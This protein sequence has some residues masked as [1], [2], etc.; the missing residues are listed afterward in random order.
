MVKRK[1]K[2]GLTLFT[3]EL[4]NGNISLSFQVLY[5]EPKKPQPSHNTS[6][7]GLVWFIGPGPNL[8]TDLFKFCFFGIMN[9][10]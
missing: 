8:C 9:K 3:K 4:P 2:L 10:V 1:T 6:Q 7:L 5:G